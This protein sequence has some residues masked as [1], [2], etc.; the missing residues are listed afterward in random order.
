MP[1]HENMR[2]SWATFAASGDPAKYL[3]Y[4]RARHNATPTQAPESGHENN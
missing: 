4:V 1:H 3:E 2:M